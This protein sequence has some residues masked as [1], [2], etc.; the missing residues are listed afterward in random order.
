MTQR[1][2]AAKAP[3]RTQE[4]RLVP[5]VPQEVADI[6]AKVRRERAQ[7]IDILKPAV[8]LIGQ[9]LGPSTELVLHDLT[10]PGASVVAIANGRLTGRRVGSPILSGPKDDV[11]FQTAV[12]MTREISAGGHAVIGVYPTISPSGAPLK[13]ATAIYRDSTGV[14][15]AALCMNTDLSVLKIARDWLDQAIQGPTVEWEVPQS[16]E[17]ADMDVLITEILDTAVKATGKP[18]VL[19]NKAEKIQAVEQMLRRGL[20]VVKGSVPRAAKAL[21]ISRYTIYNYLDHI[22]AQ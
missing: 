6:S 3:R 8:E 18:V 20:F 22:K 1:P 7:V 14:P 10:M 16:T 19:M 2:E 15:F 9:M 17:P 5:D 11:A 13:S 12:Q 4:A 21:N